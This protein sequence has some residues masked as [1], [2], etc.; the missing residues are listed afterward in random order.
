MA[1]SQMALVKPLTDALYTYEYRD[2]GGAWSNEAP[3]TGGANNPYRN[4]VSPPC[5]ELRIT[6]KTGAASSVDRIHLS[7]VGTYGALVFDSSSGLVAEPAPS[8]ERPHRT[9][10]I[11]FRVDEEVSTSHTLTITGIGGVSMGF[12]QVVFGKT[13]WSPDMNYSYGSAFQNGA[14]FSSSQSNASLYQ[15]KVFSGKGQALSLTEQAKDTLLD[16]DYL[17]SDL[18]IEGFCLFER[19]K[20]SAALD[21]SD[22][23]PVFCSTSGIT[24]TKYTHYSTSLTIKEAFSNV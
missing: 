14:Q 19:D 3:M 2:T 12:R 4:F 8:L 20:N 9:N 23:L 1:A 6:G 7:S 21:Q 17:L 10:H 18:T 16:L 11:T 24:H 13:W 15:R 5:D 22:V